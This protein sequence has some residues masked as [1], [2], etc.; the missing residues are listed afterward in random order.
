MTMGGDMGTIPHEQVI[1]AQYTLF[2]Q[3]HNNPSQQ[4]LDS[5]TVTVQ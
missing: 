2:I 5:L 3:Y 1:N 4:K